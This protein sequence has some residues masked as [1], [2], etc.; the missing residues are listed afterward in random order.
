M[1]DQ[2]QFSMNNSDAEAHS[3]HELRSRAANLIQEQRASIES[4]IHSL[5]EADARRLVSTDDVLSTALRRVDSLILRRAFRGQSDR[6]FFALVHGL[7][8]RTILE[9][10]RMS[11]RIKE[12]ERMAAENLKS[13]HKES[14]DI[15]HELHEEFLRIGRL[16]KNPIDRE[17]VLLRGRDLPF[18][19]I[20]ELMGMDPV[21]VRMRWSRL[22]ARLRDEIKGDDDQ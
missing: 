18:H 17:I 13:L 10:A 7:V 22:R 21:A 14:A 3:D 12:R 15:P 16:V 8:E 20:A 6:Q 5:L 9:K 19:T 1:D 2:S 11:R 4:R